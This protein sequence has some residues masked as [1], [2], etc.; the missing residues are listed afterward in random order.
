MDMKVDNLAGDMDLLK[1]HVS[2][3]LGE[4][5]MMGVSIMSRPSAAAG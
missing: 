4:I 1:K 5:Y 3:I 2:N